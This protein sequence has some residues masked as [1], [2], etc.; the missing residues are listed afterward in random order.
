MKKFLTLL[1]MATFFYLSCSSTQTRVKNGESLNRIEGKNLIG[2]VNRKGFEQRPFDAWFAKNYRDYK[3]KAKDAKDIKDLLNNVD[4][5]V[6]M[7]TWCPDSRREVPRLYKILD[8]AHFDEKRLTVYAV[9][10]S[11]KVP[12]GATDNLNIKRVPTIIVIRDGKE[13]GRIIEYPVF[14]LEKDLTM[15]LKGEDYKPNYLDLQ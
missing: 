8:Y 7:G 10:R 6:V 14:S 13:I 4:I 2:K 5:V 11:K 9:D 15:I 3:V 1:L 12:S